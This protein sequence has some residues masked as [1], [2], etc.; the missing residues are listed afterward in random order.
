VLVIV[1]SFARFI[2]AIMLPAR[3]TGDLLAGMWSLLA[4]QLGAVPRRLVWDNEAGIGQ[5]GPRCEEP[6]S[7]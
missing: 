6:P 3:T 4:E 7:E 5:S 2:T 1:A